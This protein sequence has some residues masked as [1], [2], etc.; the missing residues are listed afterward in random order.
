MKVAET[1]PVAPDVE[2]DGGCLVCGGVLSIRIRPGSAR[3]VC[4]T[5]GWHSRP[6][7]HREEDGFQVHHPAGGLA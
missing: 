3:S 7:L 1:P 4:R 6:H 5:C 2:L